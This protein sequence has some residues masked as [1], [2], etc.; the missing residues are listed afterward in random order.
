MPLARGYD[1]W[2]IGFDGGGINDYVRRSHVFRNVLM[3][4][5]CTQMT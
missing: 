3:L 4:N 1:F 2:I 5:D